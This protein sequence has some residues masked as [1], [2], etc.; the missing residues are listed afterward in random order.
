MG[1]KWIYSKELEDISKEFNKIPANIHTEYDGV[2]S[3]ILRYFERVERDLIREQ[4]KGG[5]NSSQA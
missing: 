1:R 3:A 4:E 2:I 5:L